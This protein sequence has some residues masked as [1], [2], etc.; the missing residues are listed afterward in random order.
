MAVSWEL[1]TDGVSFKSF[2]ASING[3]ALAEVTWWN[4]SGTQQELVRFIEKRGFK[5]FMPYMIDIKG[6]WVANL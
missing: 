2:A 5:P 4:L 6:T 1:V 3:V